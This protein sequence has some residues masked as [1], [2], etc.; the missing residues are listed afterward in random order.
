[1]PRKLRKDSVRITFGHCQ[2]DVDDHRAQAVRD[3]V[4]PDDVARSETPLACAA[5]MNSARLR[6][7]VWPRTMRAMSSQ[8]TAP[9]AT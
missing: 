4:A 1:M 5:S 2:R 3:D 7:K 8:E 9:I 6:L